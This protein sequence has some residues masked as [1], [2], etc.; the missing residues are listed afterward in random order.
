MKHEHK[1]AYIGPVWEFG[2][3]Y[4]EAFQCV[5]CY[6]IKR[7]SPYEVKGKKRIPLSEEKFIELKGGKNGTRNKFNTNKSF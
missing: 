5:T 1:F 7:E 2:N 3:I 4:R 6:K